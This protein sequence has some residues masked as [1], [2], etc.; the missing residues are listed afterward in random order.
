[1]SKPKCDFGAAAA[2]QN[3]TMNAF[4]ALKL[5]LVDSFADS[6]ALLEALHFFSLKRVTN[7]SE[8]PCLFSKVMKAEFTFLKIW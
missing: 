4:F 8:W 5:A 6:L 7:S 3:K 2:A 1:M